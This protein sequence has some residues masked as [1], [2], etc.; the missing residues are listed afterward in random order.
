MSQ[1]YNY[2]EK[3]SYKELFF[4]CKKCD[5]NGTGKQAN[6]GFDSSSGFP[7]L[8]PKCGKYIDWIDITV[9]LDELLKYGTEKDKAYARQQQLFYD[10]VT[11]SRLK[12]CDQLPE[13][14][15]D[16]IVITLRE[17]EPVDGEDGYIVLYWN[18]QEIWREIRTFEY[19]HRYVELGHILKEKYGSRIIDFE[20]EYTYYFGGDSFSAFEKAKQ[21]RKS[22]Q[23]NK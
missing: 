23:S 10:S 21:F 12:S 8:C 20:A 2:K 9:S 17:E 22:L 16:K 6:V 11:T 15:S 14:E 19:S 7:L 5:W 4:S 13:I 3:K 1:F 18:E